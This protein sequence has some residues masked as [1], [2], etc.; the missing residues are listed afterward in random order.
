[1][2]FFLAFRLANSCASFRF[3]S[4]ESDDAVRNVMD[5]VCVCVCEWELNR[6]IYVAKQVHLRVVV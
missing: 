4:D 5:I 6:S 3:G 1:M 2:N